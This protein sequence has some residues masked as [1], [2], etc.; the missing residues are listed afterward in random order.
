MDA[1]P[2]DQ[3]GHV[4]VRMED[5]FLRRRDRTPTITLR[6]D[7]DEGLQPPEVS[8]AI[9][10]ALQPV[11]AKLPQAIASRPA[12]TSKSQSRPTRRWS[13]SSRSCWR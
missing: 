4:E 11:I 5:P 8:A 12:A 1:I 9:E 3:I 10:T 7:I 2:L 6:G 13:P